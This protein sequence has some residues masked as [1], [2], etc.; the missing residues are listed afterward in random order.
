M[1]QLL[2]LFPIANVPLG[3]EELYGSS[4]KLSFRFLPGVS[5]MT[6]LDTMALLLLPRRLSALHACNPHYMTAST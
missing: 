1:S 5:L 4:Q 2:L 3:H 6:P